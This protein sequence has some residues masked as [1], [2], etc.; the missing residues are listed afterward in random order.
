MSINPVV[1]AEVTIDPG[2]VTNATGLDI[3]ATVKGLRKGYPVLVWAVSLEDNLTICNPHC[4][5]ANTLKFRLLN[6]SA[7]PIDPASQAFMVVQF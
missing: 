2:S 1:S 7:A 5:A 6:P 3:T 4:S